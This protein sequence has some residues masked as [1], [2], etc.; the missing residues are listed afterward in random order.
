MEKV[1]MSWAEEGVWFND[2]KRALEMAGASQ[3]RSPDEFVALSQ[4]QKDIYG[5][6]LSL[7][8][9]A[10]GPDVRETARNYV[11]EWES[12]FGFNHYQMDLAISLG[13]KSSHYARPAYIEGQFDAPTVHDR[14]LDLGYEERRVEGR[15]CYAMPDD[16]SIDPRKDP[17]FLVMIN[18]K[19]L[20]IDDATLIASPWVDQM[21]SI[22]GVWSGDNP[23]LA[24]DPAFSSLREVL[25]DSLSAAILSRTTAFDTSYISE[26]QRPQFKKQETWGTLHE[27][28][29]AGFGSGRV[30]DGTPW[31]AISLF[32]PD[33]GAA[34]ADVS[35][36]VHR[37]E[38]YKA[39]VW[40]ELLTR[41]YPEHSWR[42]CGPTRVSTSKDERGST[43]TVRFL[44]ECFPPGERWFSWWWESIDL[45][46]LGFLVP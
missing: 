36:L 12:A 35:E 16:R 17:I 33:P 24:E 20:Y 2:W 31:F 37:L 45:R 6:A 34:S 4:E 46:D 5:T 13:I 30:V 38:T 1:P 9:F 42:P 21:E 10:L 14:L 39:T 29:A 32:Y 23:S 26:G 18:T 8:V 41:G 15:M 25:W 3:P 43:L 22:L 7:N 28:E 27:W 19:Y 40:P 11:L 44:G